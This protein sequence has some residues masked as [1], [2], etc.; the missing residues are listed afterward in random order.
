MAP[1]QQPSQPKL[2]ANE[3]TC[4]FDGL[5]SQKQAQPQNKTGA[6][7]IS[8]PEKDPAPVGSEIPVETV[9]PAKTPIIGVLGAKGG[10]GATT[11]AVNLAAAMGA[12]GKTVTIIDGNLQQPTVSH[13]IGRDPAHS[14]MELLTRMPDLDRQLFD[15]CSVPVSDLNSNLKLLSPPLNGEAA[16]KTNLS[17]VACC[18]E[19][20]RPYSDFW[21]V[22]LP[23]HL[24]KHLVTLAD[25]CSR[26][27]LVFEATV[28][29]V[30]ATQ[31][32]LSVLRELGYEKER[33]MCL[34]NRSGSKL[35]GV[36]KQLADCFSDYAITRIPNASTLTWE[37][38]TRGV[39]VVLS[40]PTQAY[41]KAIF[42][43]AHCL[44]QF[45]S[46]GR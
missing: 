23:R 25:M 9:R 42:N 43:L 27:V 29:G 21:I 11:I 12:A 40:H 6:S 39:P 18:L 22:D 35:N 37:G 13:L 34:L 30:A 36:E 20:I 44:A 31:Q 1:K 45:T 33:I 15:A 46:G 28:P 4:L 32:W 38:S 26:I 14:I 19:Y 16:V 2:E 41:S 10:S 5:L 8:S 7:L 17:K 24:D 3:R